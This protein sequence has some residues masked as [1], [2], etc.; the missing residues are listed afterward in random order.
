MSVFLRQS[1]TKPVD[2]T[3]ATMTVKSVYERVQW[4]NNLK[5]HL[6]SYSAAVA[7]KG[8]TD[9]IATKL[10]GSSLNYSDCVKIVQIRGLEGLTDVLGHKHDGKPRVTSCKTVVKKLF[11]Y[12]TKH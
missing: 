8:L 11:N 12:I 4:K 1:V 9:F 2:L 3:P 7:N 5:S 6:K 10:A